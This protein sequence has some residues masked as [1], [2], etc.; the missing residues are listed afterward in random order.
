MPEYS[1][2]AE[3]YWTTR[4]TMPRITKVFDRNLLKGCFI[5]SRPHILTEMLRQERRL[6]AN[7]EPQNGG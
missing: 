7:S 4:K 5:H 3:H 6:T 1:L 2:H